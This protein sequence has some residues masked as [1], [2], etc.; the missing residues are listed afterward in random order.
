MEASGVTLPFGRTL[1]IV[2]HSNTLSHAKNEYA[3]AAHAFA[4]LLRNRLS[5]H[6]G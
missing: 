2:E 4:K 1:I 6:F 5:A 3:L